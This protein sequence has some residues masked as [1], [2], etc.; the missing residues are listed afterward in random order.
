[1]HPPETPEERIADVLR[2]VAMRLEVAID[3]GRRST[4]SDA[5]DLLETLLAVADE[6]DP[7]ILEFGSEPELF[8]AP[9]TQR[10]TLA[11]RGR[12]VVG[13][14]HVPSPACVA[15]RVNR[16]WWGIPPLPLKPCLQRNSR[17][18][19]RLTHPKLRLQ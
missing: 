3:E 10:P 16:P 12:L 17:K 5:N 7:P 8:P 14:E 15:T 18:V 9:G 6:L 19:E 13:V 2:L 1:M 11:T 4:R